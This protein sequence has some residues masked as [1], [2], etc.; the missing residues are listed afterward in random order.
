MLTL[1]PNAAENIGGVIAAIADL[2]RI[3]VPESYQ[4]SRSPSPSD[5]HKSNFTSQAKR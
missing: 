4:I 3:G 2:L 1:S 5:S